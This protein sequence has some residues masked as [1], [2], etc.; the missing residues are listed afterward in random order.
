MEEYKLYKVTVEK[1]FVI[2]MP[3][4]MSI[5]DIEGSVENIMIINADSLRDEGLSHV[6]VENIHH[7]G[8]L[9]GGWE[10]RCLPYLNR[11]AVNMPEELV[12]KTIEE[13]L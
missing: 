2:A 9:P 5:N 8:D 13:Y 10:G 3:S 7:L 6:L 12:N 11:R 4:S 1:E